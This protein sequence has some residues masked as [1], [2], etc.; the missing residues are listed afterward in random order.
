MQID[1]TPAELTA[2]RD[3]GEARVVR[4]MTQQP[5]KVINGEAK[6]EIWR[7][8]WLRS[9]DTLDSPF[10]PAGTREVIDD[11]PCVW[12]EGGCKQID[13]M[14]FYEA[15]DCLYNYDDVNEMVSPQQKLRANLG[16]NG[17][18]WVWVGHIRKDTE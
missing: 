1:L 13:K 14:D 11:T 8:G 4:E 3:T 18:A 16:V 7:D 2:L 12:G 5:T 15:R 6:R 9:C 17:D 10:P